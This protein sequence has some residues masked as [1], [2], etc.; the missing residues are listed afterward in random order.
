MKI[1]W[2]RIE[3]Y[4]TC[5][6]YYYY[7]YIC[8]YRDT[9]ISSA[10]FFGTSLGTTWQQILLTKKEQLTEEEKK[11]ININ[12]YIFFDNLYKTVKI[13]DNIYDLE[14]CMYARYF[15]S[16]FDSDIL[17]T[18]DNERI[19]TYKQK[20]NIEESLS[21]DIL[22]PKYETY[23]TN[24]KET[25]FINF[26]FWVSTRRKAYMLID[27]YI[28]EVLPLVHKVHRIEGKI[29]IENTNGDVLE[30]FLDVDA[31]FEYP[32]DNVQRV[33]LDHKTSSVKYSSNA[34]LT[35]QQLALYSYSEGIETQG[36]IIGLK[37]IKKPKI[38]TNKGKLQAEIQIL[39][40]KISEERQEEVIK[41]ADSVLQKIK[42]QEFEKD[43]S[44]GCLVFGKS[45]CYK[46]L[47][48][49]GCNPDYLYIKKGE[50]ISKKWE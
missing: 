4:L 26:L 5:P 40:D 15:K 42:K 12:P 47:C 31:D 38:G 41:E 7:Y 32:K 25:K 24:E 44:K 16:D 9:T 48:H 19:T 8:G 17:N 33:I 2:S 23:S 30:G 43:Y 18:E 20:N 11:I 35:K 14:D 1:S 50:N 49:K 29:S 22:Y 46:P 45:C 36:Y 28:K 10:L 13:N 27:I 39:V 34:I 21:F 6:K 3:K 37:K